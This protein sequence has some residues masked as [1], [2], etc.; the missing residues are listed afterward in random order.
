MKKIF[1]ILA[2]LLF[3]KNSQAIQL[4]T[5][6]NSFSTDG[7]DSEGNDIDQFYNGSDINLDSQGRI[8]VSGY[9][10]E[11]V[12]G[13]DIAVIFIKR[14]LSD[15]QVD[16]SFGTDGKVK[17]EQHYG[18]TFVD[19]YQVRTSLF[20]N[21]DVVLA[22]NS[23]VCDAQ[24]ANCNND[25]DIFI[26]YIKNNGNNIYEQVVAFNFGSVDDRKDDY[27]KDML[28]DEFN[29]KILLAVEVE[30]A[31]TYDVDFGIASVNIDTTSGVM[32]MDTNFSSDG[33]INCYFDQGSTTDPFQRGHYDIP[34]SIIYNPV[35]DSYIVSGAAYEGNG[36]ISAGENMAFC[37]FS[38]QGNI[39][40]Q[41][42]S[43]DLPVFTDLNIEYA[44]DSGI[45]TDNGV[46]TLWVAA[47]NMNNSFT[48]EFMLAK[49][50][51]NINI[52]ELDTSFGTNGVSIVDFSTISPQGMSSDRVKSIAIQSNGSIIIAGTSDFIASDS[53]ENYFFSIAK[54]TPS[55]SLDTTWS[56]LG[57]SWVS[58]FNSP[59]LD[60]LSSMIIDPSTGAIFITGSHHLYSGLTSKMIVA[61]LHN[62][63]IFAQ[64][65]D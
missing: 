43:K 26:K 16:A 19:N 46:T 59:K 2:V 36:D 39:I 5:L 50:D 6:D 42:S 44:V 27:L 10:T 34:Y 23:R 38:P 22:F 14:Y 65:F 56:Q 57:C 11:E 3:I 41:W 49:Y 40:R 13:L 51:F 24:G 1:L 54:F 35:V 37:E 15:G 61:K 31:N 55:G 30:M 20:A 58:T 48:P 21:D 25:E 28:L 29:N 12:G 60:N 45:A 7:W 62:D 18:F 9:N 8:I 64:G 63:V 32:S 4:G 53:S 17:F 47:T 33:L 52:W